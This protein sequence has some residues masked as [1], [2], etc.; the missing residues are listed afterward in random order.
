[1]RPFLLLVYE[2]GRLLKEKLKKKHFK[3]KIGII[4]LAAIFLLVGLKN[5]LVLREYEVQSPKVSGEVRLAVVADLHGCFYGED[6]SELIDAVHRQKPDVVLLVGDIVDDVMAREP[7][8][9]FL[10]EMSKVYPCYYVSGNHE[11]WSREY[12]DIR[13][14]IIKR[15]VNVLEGE[16]RIVDVRGEKIELLGVDDPEVSWEAYEDQLKALEGREKMPYFQI[17]LSHHPERVEDFLRLKPDL[18]VAGHAHGGQWRIP[19]LVNGIL[20][21]N[22]G[23]FPKYGGGNY[24]LGYGNLVVSR[25]LARESTRIPR[26]FNPPELVMVKIVP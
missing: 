2:G 25:G 26:L 22:Q 19:G 9:K 3:I 1:M 10:E 17:L 20:A 15:N 11:Y 4:L 13:R 12:D 14:E 23:F 16:S 24:D 7:S 18:V 5:D 21:P 8:Y 6:Q